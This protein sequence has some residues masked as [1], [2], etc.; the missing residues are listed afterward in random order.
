MREAY[1]A[2]AQR[3][4][5]RRRFAVA[6]LVASRGARASE[7]GTSLVIDA[8]GAFVGDIG[9]GC[10]EGGIVERATAALARA[11]MVSAETLTFELDDEILT[12]SGCGASL[13]VVLWSPPETFTETAEAV[14]RGD[15]DVSFELG[16]VTIEIP[17]HPRLVIVGATAL[18]AQLTTLAHHADFVVSVVDP[19]AAFAT[20]QRH[21]DADDLLVAWP[22]D[23]TV[24]ACMSDADAIV[25][26]S[27]DVKVDLPA[28]RAALATRATYVGLLGNRRVQR[29]R[30][31]A[32]LA[33]GYPNAQ[34]E[35]IFGPAGLDVGATT[36]GQ[37]ALSILAEI[38]AVRNARSGTS[39]RQSSGP[40]HP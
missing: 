2:I 1:A 14:A 24:E 34:I 30:R 13:E 18:A 36:D 16:G 9:A 17:Q 15:R 21:P 12:G 20:V 38:V 25:V 37:T 40:I 19:R 27:H 23:S 28:L 5:D 3:L 35:R 31:E 32:L 22:D 6:T 11:P 7:I 39:L 26:L 4:R 33:Q 10:H 8:D 29:A